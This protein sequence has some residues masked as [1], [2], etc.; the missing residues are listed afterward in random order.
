[1]LDRAGVAVKKEMQGVGENLQDHLQLRLVFGVD[2]V[3]TLNKQANSLIGQVKIGLEYITSGTGPMASAP[4][5]LGAFVKSSEEED[6]PNLQYHVQPLSLPAF[7]QDLDDFEA[8][9]VSVCDLRPTSRGSVHISSAGI[10]L[11]GGLLLYL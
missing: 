2:N 6:R 9:T 3:V 10:I 4:S 1:M 8:F 11:R 7:G 5:Q